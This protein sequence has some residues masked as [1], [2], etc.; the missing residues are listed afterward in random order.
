MT[1]PIRKN[2][3][4]PEIIQNKPKE[5][6]PCNGCGVCCLS[7]QCPVSVEVFGNQELCPALEKTDD[8]EYAA[9]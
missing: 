5:G 3:L 6:D 7:E 2:C 1:K 9:K 8:R 4:T